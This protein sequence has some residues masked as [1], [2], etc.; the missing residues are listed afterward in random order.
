MMS[1]CLFIRVHVHYSMCVNLSN[2]FLRLLNHQEPT[3]VI[4]VEFSR[5]FYGVC[6][7]ICPVLILSKA[8]ICHAFNQ[9]IVAVTLSD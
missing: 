4:Q 1:I 3:F 6:L 2:F 7:F 8:Q 5:S 9:S